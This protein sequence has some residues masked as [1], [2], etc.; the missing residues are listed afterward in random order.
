MN[1]SFV[2]TLCTIS[3]SGLTFDL[4]RLMFNNSELLGRRSLKWPADDRQLR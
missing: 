2:G 1:S 4:C 3:F